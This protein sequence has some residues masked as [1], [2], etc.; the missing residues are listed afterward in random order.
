MARSVLCAVADGALF[1]WVKRYIR[2]EGIRFCFFL[3]MRFLFCWVF[4]F[5]AYCICY[6][7]NCMDV[8]YY[9]TIIIIFVFYF[10][11]SPFV[12]GY[13]S[14]LFTKKYFNLLNGLL[15]VV[16]CAL[17][18]LVVMVLF[19]GIYHIIMNTPLHK[20]DS[21][22]SFLSIM[23]VPALIG[24]LLAGLVSASGPEKPQ[25]PIIPF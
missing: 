19:I 1:V 18:S 15:I 11:I 20:R 9:C 14:Y 4:C 6:S 3:C 12:G 25:R 7:F 13:F 24:I 21:Y 10:I 8:E 22:H 17:A 5:I 16:L 2:Y 23:A